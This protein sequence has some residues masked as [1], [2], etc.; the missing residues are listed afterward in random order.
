MSFSSAYAAVSNAD[1]SRQRANTLD[2]EENRAE[3]QQRLTALQNGY[4]Q[5]EQGNWVPTA[6]QQQKQQTASQQQQILQEQLQATQQAVQA[7]KAKMNA[8]ALANITNYWITKNPADAIKQLHNTPGLKDVLQNAQTLDFKD[9]DIIN[10][11]N[12]DDVDKLV[13]MGVDRE[14]LKDPEVQNALS[15]SFMKI[16]G[17]DGTSRLVPVDHV[18]KQTNSMQFYTTQQRDLYAE[19]KAKYNSIIKGALPQE[20]DIQKSKLETQN[21]ILQQQQEDMKAY[22][23][24]NPNATYADFQNSQLSNKNNLDMLKE[25]LDIK[26][27]QLELEGKTKEAAVTNYVSTSPKE[28]FD[29]LSKSDL[30]S[31]VNFGGTP[32]KIYQ[33]AKAAQGDTKLSNTRRDYLDGMVS[34]TSNIGRL[35][36]KLKNASFDWNALAKGMDKISKITGTEWRNMSPQEKASMLKR[37]SFDSDLRTVM[38]GYIKAMSGAA[39]SDEERTFYENAVQ[40]GN[41]STKEA[42][43]ASMKGFE[44]GVYNGVKAS[45]ESMK[46]NVPAT[47][48]E[49]KSQLNKVHPE[50][51]QQQ[52]QQQ[53]ARPKFSQDQVMQGFKKLFPDV[54]KLTDLT[55]EQKQKLV[56]YL[57]GN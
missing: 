40:G 2:R 3:K 4:T 35:K 14:A 52:P 46:Y 21:Q 41:W 15:H 24:K 57:K 51:P 23:E 49:Y 45:L 10:F 25:K 31:T 32:I 39:V 42:A 28:F 6:L 44:S 27:K 20:V 43:L 12:P 37:F 30:N 29:T 36:T 5:D 22:F 55:V 8:D 9:L 11:N 47:Y 50:Q 38:A 56:N 53:E 17:K 33:A 54:D 13:D 18:T 19:N 1:T 7:Q 48:L 26:S 34:T 16:Q